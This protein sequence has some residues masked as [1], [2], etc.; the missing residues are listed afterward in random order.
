MPDIAWVILAVVLGVFV[1]VLLFKSIRIV[2]QKRAM[3]VERLG[4]FHKDAQA[5]L[6]VLMPFVDS[7]RAVV[8]LREQITSIEP[9]PVIT[10]DNVTMSV[11]AVIYYIIINPVQATYE[12]QNLSW[13]LE[14]L[15]LS[16]LRNII[17]E[18]DL[19]H[20][21]TSRD[22]VNTRLRSAL[23]S[24][25][26]QWG[27]KV[28]RVEMKNITPPEEIRITMEKQMTAERNRRA[29]V[30]TAEGEKS[31]AVL[32][33]E[34][35]KQSAVISAEGSQQSAILAAEGQAQARLRVA[36]AEAQAIQLVM[37]ALGQEG[38]SAQYLIAQKYLE[39]LGQIA[40]NAQKVV[41]LPFEASAVMGS[42][43]SLKELLNVSPSPVRPTLTK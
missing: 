15:T 16:N 29:V 38:D 11:D 6:H 36:Q 9:Q 32:R 2:G 18:L 28:V 37:N 5:G 42:L 21:L 7:V 19:D 4:R 23:D 35:Q 3:I 22:M 17:G 10:R 40:N 24:A 41:F 39:S 25:T 27:V 20:T 13:G 30:T 43:G 1:L 26:A 14:Q 12:I 33:A 8:D 34:G 31:A